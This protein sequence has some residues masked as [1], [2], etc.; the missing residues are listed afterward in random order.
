MSFDKIQGFLEIGTKDGEV[1][2][3][4]DKDRTGHIKFSPSQARNLAAILLTK[5]NEI[6]P[7]SWD[8]KVEPEI[9][10]S[11]T[12]LHSAT[13][14]MGAM[15]VRGF[16]E[17][18]A[19]QIVSNHYSCIAPHKA[20]VP[21]D[22]V[23]P[24]IVVDRLS[25]GRYG[26][27]VEALGAGIG[28]TW[29]EAYSYGRA[30]LD[31]QP[32]EAE[33]ARLTHFETKA[34]A[35]QSHLLDLYT[36]TA[37]ALGMK[38]YDDFDSLPALARTCLWELNAVIRFAMDIFLALDPAYREKLADADWHLFDFVTSKWS[39]I[40]AGSQTLLT[41]A[42]IARM[43]RELQ[44]NQH[45]GNWPDWIP[46]LTNAR[47]ELGHHFGKLDSQL[48][49]GVSEERARFISEFTADLANIAMKI[50]DTFGERR[51]PAGHDAG[52]YSVRTF[53]KPRP[54]TA[55]E[56]RLLHDAI[57]P[58]CNTLTL[59][60]GPEGGE[61]Q[62]VKCQT[63]ESEWNVCPLVPSCALLVPPKVTS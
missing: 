35:E 11:K 20:N 5:A 9:G 7:G 58:V 36:Q 61:C 50:A 46:N 37:V 44:A 62:N 57:C 28:E 49:A 60:G 27:Q 14:I 17:A 29:R 2:I 63:C 56:A 53:D 47:S 59:L 22:E 15:S 40:P 21:F 12:P 4:L 8:W 39:A 3:N 6:D 24:R 54:C 45:K 42:F 13:L 34:R 18:T 43:E 48:R 55:E 26:Y 38:E 19:R 32:L 52:A 31:R 16:D 41:L 30:L 33:V 51:I 10:D 1:V 25:D 23:D